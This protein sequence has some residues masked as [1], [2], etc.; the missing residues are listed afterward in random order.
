MTVFGE[1]VGQTLGL[2]R[3]GITG[4]ERNVSRLDKRAEVALKEARAKLDEV[5]ELVPKRFEGLGRTL[6][7]ALHNVVVT[8]GEFA[9]LVA[10]VDALAEKVDAVAKKQRR[11][12]AHA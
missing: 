3:D 1:T 12:A 11:P 5:R 7:T 10:K 2:A 4:F 8:R 9:S 6:S